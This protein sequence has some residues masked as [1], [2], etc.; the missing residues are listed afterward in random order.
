VYGAGMVIPL[1][2]IAAV[3]QRSG[4]RGR[5]LLQGRTFTVFGRRFHTTSVLTG[6]LIITVGVVFWFTNGLVS[7][8][9]LVPTDVQAWSQRQS[10]LLGDPLVD[11]A[12]I[13]ILAALALSVW[14]FRRRRTGH[15]RPST[16]L[17]IKATT[18][19]RQDAD[20]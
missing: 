11:V 17:G 19:R 6:T 16:D 12:G 13:V 18:V 3:W 4:N 7:M 20:P 9:S 1:V 14:A 2:I 8:P 5:R 15:D 10:A